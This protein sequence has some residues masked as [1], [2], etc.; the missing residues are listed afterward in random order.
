MRVG[1]DFLLNDFDTLKRF[2][3]YASKYDTEVSVG[4]GKYIVDGKSILGMLSL[5]LSNPV[6]VYM[7]YNSPQKSCMMLDRLFSD[8]YR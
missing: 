6:T 8:V 3:N 2:V 7:E 1:K 5:D 4:V